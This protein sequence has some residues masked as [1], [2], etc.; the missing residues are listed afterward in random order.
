MPAGMLWDAATGK[1]LRRWQGHQGDVRALAFSPD[2]KRLASA[3]SDT[4]ILVWDVAGLL[5]E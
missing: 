4:T 2:G 5:A 3:G 1:D